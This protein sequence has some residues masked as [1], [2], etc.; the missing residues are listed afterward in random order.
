VS[1]DPRKRLSFHQQH[2]LKTLP[3]RIENLTKEIA[4]L[5]GKLADPAL[6]TRDRKAFDK[7]SAG[8]AEKAAELEA[9]ET[10]W[11]ELEILREEI[12]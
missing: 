5:Q 3:S 1:A 7:A 6:F 12:G 9:A 8:V 4:A 10:E 11:L 2:A